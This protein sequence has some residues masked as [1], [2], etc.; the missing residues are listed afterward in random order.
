MPRAAAGCAAGQAAVT[1]RSAPSAPR[2]ALADT[3]PSVL[4]AVFLRLA[5]CP[6]LDVGH[7][8]FESAHYRSLIAWWR[9][10]SASHAVVSYAVVGASSHMES[11]FRRTSRQCGAFWPLSC[12][13]LFGLCLGRALLVSEAV[14]EMIFLL[15]CMRT[16]IVCLEQPYLLL[17][18]PPPPLFGGGLFFVAPP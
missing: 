15:M 6:S 9:D 4:V 11:A 8:P 3:L 5:M 17:P 10:Q 16:L 1:R 13:E 12:T 7:D 14:L 18:H 2:G